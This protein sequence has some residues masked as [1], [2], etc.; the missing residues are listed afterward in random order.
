[1]EFLNKTNNFKLFKKRD[2]KISDLK[3]AVKII[4]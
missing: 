1:M 4:A 2:Y 3:I